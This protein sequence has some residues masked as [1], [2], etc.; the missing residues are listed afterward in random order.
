MKAG[1]IDIIKRLRIRCSVSLENGK[2]YKWKDI[3]CTLAML[4]I[5]ERFSHIDESFESSVSFKGEKIQF[6]GYLPV[7]YDLQ[8]KFLGCWQW[9]SITLLVL[10][11]LIVIAVI[12]FFV[13]K[14]SSKSKDKKE[15][16]K[17]ASK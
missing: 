5:W 6:N 11:I 9:W 10:L 4:N 15:V 14:P 3:T 17:K 16:P 2:T 1:D 8:S 7:T 13:L 12:L